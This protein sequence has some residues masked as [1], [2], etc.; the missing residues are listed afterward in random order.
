MEEECGFC[1]RSGLK[2]TFHHLIP[3]KMHK[4]KY[5]IKVHPNHDFNTYGVYLCIP[6]HK[7]LH[8]V[9]SHKELALEYY[10][11][12]KIMDSEE[13]R[14]AIKFNAKQKKQKKPS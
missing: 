11:V 7:Q 3:K 6:C 2:L 13:M 5:V 10:E 14:Y 8:K 4:K 1:L 12:A 9:F